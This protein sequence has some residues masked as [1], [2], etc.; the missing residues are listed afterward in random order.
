MKEKVFSLILLFSILLFCLP[1]VFVEAAEIVDFKDK[2]ILFTIDQKGYQV[3]DNLIESDIAPYLKDLGNGNKR[4]MVPV[5]FLAQALGKEPVK[6]FSNEQM[7]LITEGEK[8]IAIF[9]GKDEML[10]NGKK[11]YMDVPAELKNVGNGGGRTMLPINFI[12]KALGVVYEWDETASTVYFY[13]QTK[14]YDQKGAFGPDSG[15]QTIEGSVM[16]KADGVTLQNMLIKGNLIIAEEVGVGDVTLNNITVKG[17]TY[18]RGGGKDSIHINGG[19]YNNITIQNLNGQVRIMANDVKGA[20]VIIAEEAQGEK[21]IFEGTFEKITVEAGETYISAQGLTTINQ[22]FIQES[23]INTEIELAGSAVVKELVVHAPAYLHGQG[24]VLKAFIN[25]DNVYLGVEVSPEKDDSNPESST[26]LPPNKPQAAPTGLIAH[27]PTTIENMDGRI[28]GVSYEM[29][30]RLREA[31]NWIDIEGEEISGLAPGTYQ[32]RYKAKSGYYAGEIAEVV[33][34]EYQETPSDAYS[35]SININPQNGGAVS[36]AD[37]VYGMARDYFKDGEEII[38]TAIPNEGY[39]FLNWTEG[40]GIEVSTDNPYIFTMPANNV[41][42]KLN[43]E[44]LLIPISDISIEGELRVGKTMVSAPVPSEAI[45]SF[46]WQRADAEDGEYIDIAGATE[47]AYTLTDDEEGKWIRVLVTGLDNY[48][49]LV[50]SKG[51]GPVEPSV[52]QAQVK[53]SAELAEALENSIVKLINIMNDIE[54]SKTVKIDRPLTINGGGNTI[55]FTGDLSGWQGNHL[56]Q[57]TDTEE[58]VINDIK[59]AGGDAG[60]LV[61]DSKVRL[62]GNIDLSENE[63]GGIELLKVAEEACPLLTISDAELINS[64]ET[65]GLP[66]IWE[67]G[68]SGKVEGFNGTRI[69]YSVGNKIQEHYYLDEVNSRSNVTDIKAKENVDI[70]LEIN[71]TLHTVNIKSGVPIWKLKDAIISMD[72][73]LQKYIVTDSEGNKIAY[74][75]YEILPHFLLEVIAEAGNKQIYSFIIS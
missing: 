65:Y 19:Q 22:L 61:K 28:T 35:V 1:N 14:T 34:P 68:I 59:L 71:N 11:V 70:I 45:V 51:L 55:H 60:L 49:G 12:A 29:E 43:F 18:I 42:L 50:Q 63:F 6:W 13:G 36:V 67:T 21:I 8:Q 75:G 47:R 15:N 56:I 16:I 9:I 2:T 74:T 10:V 33:I 4:V 24:M 69:T 32:V 20:Q 25:A 58:V 5:A 52:N 40:E 27:P 23:A 72:G 57:A 54:T 38:L 48:S 31:N 7:V 30:Y 64:T 39:K 46:Q 37:A 62:K 3:G 41:C 44:L 73:S 26:F 53:T 17:E 66:T